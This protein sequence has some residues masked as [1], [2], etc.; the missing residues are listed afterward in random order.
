[1]LRA[2]ISA[3]GFL[4][5][6]RSIGCQVLYQANVQCRDASNASR[7]LGQGALTVWRGVGDV[8]VAVGKSRVGGEKIRPV[9]GAHQVVRD[10]YLVRAG[11]SLYDAG[12]FLVVSGLDRRF[13]PEVGHAR[14]VA[15]QRET[16]L[17]QIHFGAARVFDGHPVLGG[18]GTPGRPVPDDRW[19]FAVLPLG[20][21][22]PDIRGNR[23]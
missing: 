5:A 10:E 17:V 16:G 2:S 11:K 12:D 13:V 15:R 20:I 1:M 19:D 14:L 18:V 21:E 9:L 7:P 22:E 4:I 23:T 8:V 6:A 3:S